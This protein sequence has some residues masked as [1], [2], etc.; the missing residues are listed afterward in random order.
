MRTAFI[1]AWTL[2]AFALLI[3]IGSV[4]GLLYKEATP[5]TDSGL[6][7]TVAIL[8]IFGLL[9]LRMSRNAPRPAY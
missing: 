1:I 6:V 8:L 9:A 4:A 3:A 5:V 7:A 2:I